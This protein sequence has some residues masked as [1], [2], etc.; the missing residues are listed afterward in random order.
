MSDATP[1]DPSIRDRIAKAIVDV[2]EALTRRQ[3]GIGSTITIEAVV[4]RSKHS[5]EEVKRVVAQLKEDGI[6]RGPVWGEDDFVL[7]DEEAEEW[8]ERLGI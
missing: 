3:A 7:N 2:D 6:V 1:L 4:K 8:R 5:A